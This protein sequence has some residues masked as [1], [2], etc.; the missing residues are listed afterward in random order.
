MHYRHIFFS[1]LTLFNLSLAAEIVPLDQIRLNPT[2]FDQVS[3]DQSPLDQIV[4]DQS[5]ELYIGPEIYHVHRTKAGG[6][7]QNG[8]IYGIRA[9]Y[10]RIKN[11]TF[12]LGAEG[13]YA[14]GT[15]DGKSANGNKLKSHF[16]D[17]MIEGR[18]GYTLGTTCYGYPIQISPY[19]GM[20]HF[21]EGNDYK[22][23]T[24]LHIHTLTKFNYVTGGFLSDRKSVV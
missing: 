10:N 19:G 15:L 6:T 20:G 23:P 12:Y 24:P 9:G 22:K 2:P 7:K 17:R 11:N 1:M 13:L 4:L 18:L 14:T 8:T 21:E 3:P 5:Q 16:T